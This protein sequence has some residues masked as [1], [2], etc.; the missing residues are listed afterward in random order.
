MKFGPSRQALA[1]DLEKLRTKYTVL[2]PKKI[3]EN[4][5]IGPPP[6]PGGPLKTPERKSPS[7]L[8]QKNGH[9]AYNG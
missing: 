7:L 5:I 9:L 3:A 8:N 6:K 2:K 4:V 1:A